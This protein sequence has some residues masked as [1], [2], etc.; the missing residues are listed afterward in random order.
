[1]AITSDWS[2]V[3]EVIPAFAFADSRGQLME[4]GEVSLATPANVKLSVSR[5]GA[6]R[7]LHYQHEPFQQSKI[8]R[9][10]HGRI[11]DVAVDL[12][13]GDLYE[14]QLDAA[15]PLALFI[16][17][18]FAHGFQSLAEQSTIVYISTNRYAPE[19]ERAFCPDIRHFPG[20]SWQGDYGSLVVSGKDSAA[21]AFPFTS[22]SRHFR[23]ADGQW[24]EVSAAA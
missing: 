4:V 6:L 2:A 11:L 20:F 1:V 15:Q 16:P 5:L 14:I 7:G 23:H 9:V 19:A 17:G 18:H 22:R 21:P 3:P 12:K 8:I 24:R 13:T 10:C